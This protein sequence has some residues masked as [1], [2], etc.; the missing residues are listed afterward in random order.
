MAVEEVLG[1]A[2]GDDGAVIVKGLSVN[3]FRESKS[4]ATGFCDVDH[5]FQPPYQLT[6]LNF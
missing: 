6:S 4:K 5:F 1:D 2:A 3:F